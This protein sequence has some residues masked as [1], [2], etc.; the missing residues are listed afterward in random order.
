[1]WALGFTY[2]GD[3][4]WQLEYLRRRAQGRMAEIAGSRFAAL[5]Y[6]ARGLR[7][8]DL[9]AKLWEHQSSESLARRLFPEFVSG[10]NAQIADVRDRPA[11]LP[12]EFRRLGIRPSPADPEELLALVYLYGALLTRDAIQ[13]RLSRILASLR[14][15]SRGPCENDDADSVLPILHLATLN[16]DAAPEIVPGV[17][18]ER[19][20][21]DPDSC[22]VS[23][24]LYL[25]EAMRKRS[26]AGVSRSPSARSEGNGS[27]NWAVAA[28]RSQEGAALFACDP[29]LELTDPPIFYEVTLSCPDVRFAGALLA[30]LPFAGVGFN[31]AVAWGSTNLGV[32]YSEFVYEPEAEAHRSR[33]LRPPSVRI[34]FPPGFRAPLFF[35]PLLYSR[36]GW[37]IHHISRRSGI[38]EAWRF[39]TAQETPP[40]PRP[41]GVLTMFWWGSLVT[42]FSLDFV[43]RMLAA[44]NISEFRESLR[45][46]SLPPQ[47]F[48]FADV[49]GRIGFQAAGRIPARTGESL[50]TL[51]DPAGFDALAKRFISFDDLPRWASS[52]G[53]SRG[54]VATANNPPADSSYR[55]AVPGVF[56]EE[57]RAARIVTALSENPRLSANDMT[58]LQGDHRVLQAAVFLPLLLRC[59]RGGAASAAEQRCLETLRGWDGDARADALAPLVF[60][61]WMDEIGEARARAGVSRD[62]SGLFYDLLRD[63]TD[64]KD[65]A[66]RAFSRTARIVERMREVTRDAGGPRW[67]D[68]HRILRRHIL[69]PLFKAYRHSSMPRAGDEGTVDPGRAV[70]QSSRGLPFWIQSHGAAYRFVAVLGDPP[71][72]YS[73]LPGA[74]A[75]RE[76]LPD[77][78]RLRWEDY[79]NHRYRDLPFP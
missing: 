61:V 74:S 28:E 52:D 69:S 26:K 22:K 67:G 32:D 30:G 34:P 13:D 72:L 77:A 11:R 51:W 70:R 37:V 48:V 1:M 64:E 23:I 5:D 9:G 39:L 54:F 14:N 25:S 63:S 73:A 36:R 15:P 79:L 56:G 57:Y 75:D 68:F 8:A 41:P 40:R 29:H 45:E 33:R 46:F 27:N 58:A 66:R 53:D 16:E 3:R 18:L 24:Q 21:R 35:K 10:V 2:A 59:L 38:R 12:S 62:D 20:S 7:L 42:D 19:W 49:R 17:S 6:V 71:R 31:G 43:Y 44:R 60:R 78:D 47:N 50:R 4:L 65:R 55:F 76:Q